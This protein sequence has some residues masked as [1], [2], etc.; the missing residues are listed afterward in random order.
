[1][2]KLDLCDKSSS[3]LTELFQLANTPDKRK[4]VREYFEFVSSMRYASN[5]SQ[6][7]TKALLLGIDT[8]INISYKGQEQLLF[9]D[10]NRQL[11][12]IK[13]WLEGNHEIS[14]YTELSF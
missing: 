4:I 14:M 5:I 1:V 6:G 12:D 13:D 10:Y 9:N 2:S 7:V 8:I 11:S 3:V